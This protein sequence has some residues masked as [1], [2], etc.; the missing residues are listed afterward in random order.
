MK[1]VIQE[2]LYILQRIK[3]LIKITVLYEFKENNSLVWTILT[4][5]TGKNYVGGIILIELKVELI[6][7]GKQRNLIPNTSFRHDEH[8]QISQHILN[9]DAKSI[10]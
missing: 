7:T 2:T 6:Q 8:S 5:L 3:H 4:K 9:S 10:L 1:D